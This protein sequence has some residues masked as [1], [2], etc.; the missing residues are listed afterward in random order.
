[1]R[2]LLADDDEDIRDVTAQL[3][4]RAG[5]E[6]TTAHNAQAALAVLGHQSFDAL[7]LD[8]DMPPGS[9]MDVAA[10]RRAEG[11]DVPIVL[12]T[13][14]AG[15]LDPAEVARLELHVL[16]KAE[17]RRLSEVLTEITAGPVS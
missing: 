16:N 1:M 6:V 3:L 7:V 13:G 12:W 17:V 9:G 5:W 8:Q 14:W 2:I 4:G 11:D 15:T 10:A